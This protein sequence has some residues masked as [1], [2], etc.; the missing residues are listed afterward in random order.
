MKRFSFSVAF[1]SVL[2]LLMSVSVS[3]AADPVKIRSAWIDEHETFLVWY[4]HE[5]GWDKEE[6]IDLELLFFDSGMAQLD[7]MMAFFCCRA[8]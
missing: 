2:F 1:V 5:K 8:I 6:G 7:A 4:A 3:F